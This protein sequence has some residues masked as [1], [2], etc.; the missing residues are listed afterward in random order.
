[1]EVLAAGMM[2]YTREELEALSGAP[3]SEAQAL[4]WGEVLA[5]LAAAG[6]S[7]DY[8]GLLA[9][10]EPVNSR[11]RRASGGG[12]K[13]AAPQFSEATEMGAWR[14]G[15]S[16]VH[17]AIGEPFDQCEGVEYDEDDSDDDYDGILKP[18]FAVDGEPDFESGEPLDGFEYLRRVRWEANQIP[19]VKVAKID[20]GAARKE[21]TPYM[22][23]IPDIPK[24]S[25]DLCASKEWEDSFITYFSETRL[26]FSELDSSD[27]PSVSGAPKNSLK[28]GSSPE[29]QIDPTLTMIR[30]MDAVS[31]ATTLQNYTNMIQSYDTLSRNDCLWLFA[32]CIAVQPPLDAET[33]ASLRSLLRKCATILAEKKDMD[34]E[35]V[36]LNILM[37]ISGRYFGQYEK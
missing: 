19:R 5:S 10:D 27:G 29:M 33:C 17:Q 11:G 20:L 25:P 35:V 22:P 12:R 16:G 18:A 23:E 6:F 36:M 34:D 8:E 14:N 4:R 3:S 1:M 24:C 31:R 21:Q 30:S 26:T 32:L 13:A 37:S 15:D 7:G 28:P 2:R 9:S